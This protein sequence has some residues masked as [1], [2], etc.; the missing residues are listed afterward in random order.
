MWNGPNNKSL[1]LSHGA[2]PLHGKGCEVEY[3]QSADL[4]MIV[5]AYLI[6]ILDMKG[7]KGERGGFVYEVI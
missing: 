2:G 6:G 3:Q 4:S 5:S 1:F 7:R